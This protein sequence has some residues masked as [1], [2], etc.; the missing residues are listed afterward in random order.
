M[1]R[2]GR[3]EHQEVPEDVKNSWEMQSKQKT[4][5]EGYSA[6]VGLEAQGMPGALSISPASSGRRNESPEDG[7]KLMERILTREN[8]VKA[9]QRVKTNQGSHGPDGMQVEE[10]QPYLW[11]TWP[12]IRQ[13]L[14]AGDYHPQP[15]RR[16]EIPKPDGGKRELGIP[17][18]IDRLIQ[19]AVAQ[20]LTKQF[21]PEF[22]ENSYGFRPGRSAHQ[23]V[24][25]A[26][27]HI[28]DGYRIVVDI[29]LEKFFDRVNHD[30]L[31]A[32]IARKVEDRRV[33][34]LIR[35]YLESGVLQ[36]GVKV[37]SEA[38][39]PQ[40]GPLSP[41]LANILLD[42]LDKELEKRGHRFCRYADD[43]APRKRRGT[44]RQFKCCA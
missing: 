12:T 31:M 40:G 17:N 25:A 33:L 16:V 14:L 18:V 26:R 24:L 41:L 22:S 2:K 11:E 23:A 20:E 15:V 42:E 27:E 43:C 10:L 29:D 3:A 8:M 1:N 38:G 35:R 13:Q 37:K 4:S 6:E 21:D 30:K 5:Q 36:N 19:Q 39:T 28:Q 44:V 9:Y 7:K 34:R 32:L